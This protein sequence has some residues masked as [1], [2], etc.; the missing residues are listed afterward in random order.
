MTLDVVDELNAWRAHQGTVDLDAFVFATASGKHRDK[1]NV[2]TVLGRVVKQANRQRA[3]SGRAALPPVIPHTLRRTYISLMLEAGAPLHYVM[4]QVGHED[5]KTTLEIYAQVQ[6]RLSRPQVK[7][8][9]EALLAETDLDS[10]DIPAEAREMLSRETSRS[11]KKRSGRK[12]KVAGGPQSGPQTQHQPPEDDLKLPHHTQKGPDFQGLSEWARL[13]SNQRPL[14]CEASALPLSYA[15]SRSGILRG[16]RERRT[17]VSY[18][19]IRFSP[20]TPRVT[21]RR[22]TNS[23]DARASAS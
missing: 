20:S 15:P 6:K 21:P 16:R 2:R 23:R 10:A 8:A 19:R 12:A 18:N 4:D 22:S 17:P 11:A 13:G 3:S 5:S 14:A 7:R 9:F 1:D